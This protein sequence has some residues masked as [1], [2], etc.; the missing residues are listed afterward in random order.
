MSKH[1][2]NEKVSPLVWLIPV[3]FVLAAF[4]PLTIDHPMPPKA[5]RMAATS[6]GTEPAASAPVRSTHAE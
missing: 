6:S 2:P 5:E 1:D 3:P 4:L